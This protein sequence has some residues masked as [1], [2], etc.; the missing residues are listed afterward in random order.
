MSQWDWLIKPQRPYNRR[1]VI[2]VIVKA[3]LLFVVANLVYIVFDPL[4]F[5]SRITLYN[6]L[7]PGRNRLAYADNPT[8]AY[9]IS[10]ARLE[11]LFASH[12]ISSDA[13]TDDEFRVLVLGDS[14]VWGWLLNNNETLNACLN[15][16]NYRTADGRQLKAFNLGYPITNIFKD[17]LI[18]DYALQYDADAVVWMVTLEGFYDP[19]QLEHPIIQ[20]NRE[21]ALKLINDFQLSL[22]ANALRDEQDLL[23]R[24]IWGQR[25]DLAD[26]LRY[27]VYGVAWLTAGFDHTNPKYFESP[28]SNFDPTE[29]L[30]DRAYIEIGDL[31]ADILALDVLNAGIELAQQHDVEVL[32]VNEPIFIGTGINSDLRYNYLYPR[33]AYDQYRAMIGELATQNHWD[34]LD[35]WDYVPADRFTDFP[36][37]FD[38]EETCRVADSIAPALLGLAD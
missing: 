18:L 22:D 19:D 23:D 28:R 9:N 8:E 34:Y 27:Q 13:K 38:A 20:N 14:G 30:P 33:W 29:G 35:L 21:L 6:N 17:L 11:G 15:A 25:R 2:N 7:L 5:L 36:L 24:S 4:P 37:Q 3:I 10:L 31:P 16:Q 1:F 26:L 32:L 12:R